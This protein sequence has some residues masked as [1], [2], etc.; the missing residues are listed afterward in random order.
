MTVA[1]E[2]AGVIDALVAIGIPVGIV[3]CHPDD[4]GK[5]CSC[6]ALRELS[7]LQIGDDVISTG[8]RPCCHAG[9]GTARARAGARGWPASTIWIMKQPRSTHQ[10]GARTFSISSGVDSHSIEEFE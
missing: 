3:G 9:I 10:P 1:I 7:L 2:Y 6:G 8:L 5:V 4:F